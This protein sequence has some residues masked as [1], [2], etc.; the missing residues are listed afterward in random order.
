MIVHAKIYTMDEKRPWRQSLVFCKGKIVAVG[1]DEE[2]GRLRGI[3]TKFIDAGGKLVLPGLTDCHIHFIDGGFSLKR[4]NL[5]DAKDVSEIQG[6]LRAYLEQ[7]P[8]E[9]WMGEAG[10]MPCSPRDTCP[11]KSTSATLSPMPPYS[12]EGYDGHT[13]WANSKAL[14]LA[15]SRKRRLI[16]RIARLFAIPRP[17]N[18]RAP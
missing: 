2:V 5:E 3:G 18:P 15:E 4:A 6:R 9:Q 10:T 16:C 1:T 17:E 7:H 11:T 12:S 13:Y 14:A 8:D